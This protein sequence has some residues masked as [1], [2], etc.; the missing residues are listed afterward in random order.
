MH[1]CLSWE[2]NICSGSESILLFLWNPKV[3]YHIPKNFSVLIDAISGLLKNTCGRRSVL[4][5]NV[6]S[7][8]N[9]IIPLMSLQCE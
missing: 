8:L 2:A 3:H 7:T 4:L 1:Q 6:A 5:S 9:E